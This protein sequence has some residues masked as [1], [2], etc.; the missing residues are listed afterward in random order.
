MVNIRL[1]AT[2]SHFQ[3]LG[4][5]GKT[6]LIEDGSGITRQEIRI[7]WTHEVKTNI[8]LGNQPKRKQR[9]RV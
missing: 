3:I 1:K 5:H 6:Q 2:L 7:K 9:K 8:R 4:K